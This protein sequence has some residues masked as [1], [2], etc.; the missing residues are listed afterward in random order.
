MFFWRRRCCG[1]CCCR[2]CCCCCWT[3]V[4]RLAQ[5]TLRPSWK[6]ATAITSLFLYVVYAN[7]AIYVL[8]AAYVIQEYSYIFKCTRGS[9]WCACAF[10]WPVQDKSSHNEHFSLDF[11]FFFLLASC[12]KFVVCGRSQCQY[13]QETSKCCL[14]VFALVC[15]FGGLKQ[16]TMQRISDT[17]STI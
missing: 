15:V 1:C 4:R 9:V 17:D 13:Q 10:L 7:Y 3:L 5:L 6:S 8:C 12:S 14:N 11:C 16:R 2:C